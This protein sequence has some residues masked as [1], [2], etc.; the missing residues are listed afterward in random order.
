MMFTFR[1]LA[2]FNWQQEIENDPL[3]SKSSLDHESGAWRSIVS[4]QLNSNN[5]RRWMVENLNFFGRFDT[6]KIIVWKVF[7]KRRRWKN[8]SKIL[9]NYVAQMH[10]IFRNN[11]SVPLWFSLK[12]CCSELYNCSHINSKSENVS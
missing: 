12:F 10:C 11:K 8:Y 1:L 5:S 6:E 2:T 9:L 7:L 4:T 3:C